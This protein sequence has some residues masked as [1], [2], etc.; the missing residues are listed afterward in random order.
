MPRE[1]RGLGKPNTLGLD[2]PSGNLRLSAM[3]P[4][5]LHKKPPYRRTPETPRPLTDALNASR[6]IG[7]SKILPMQPPI[8]PQSSNFPIAATN[9]S[10]LSLDIL[11]DMR[12]ISPVNQKETDIFS[13]DNLFTSADVRIAISKTEEEL[14][15][16]IDAFQAL[17][18]R[19]QRQILKQKAH[20]LPTTTP[21]TVDILLE[22][23]EWR[24]HRRIPS[25]PRS[26]PLLDS[27]HRHLFASTTR[28]SFASD[29]TSLR[30]ASSYKTDLSHPRSTASI[31]G[32]GSSSRSTPLNVGSPL[33]VSV[34]LHA[35]GK[36]NLAPPRKNS[37]SSTTTSMSSLKSR[38]GT[39]RNE[40]LLP[41]PKPSSSAAGDLRLSS[42]LSRSRSHLGLKNLKGSSWMF[43]EETLL[44]FSSSSR[45][46]TGYARTSG[47]SSRGQEISEMEID[48]DPALIDVR[49]R[50]E[51]LIARYNA[52]LEFLR[53]KLKSAELH[54]RLL[55]K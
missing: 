16:L 9:M 32:I 27:S 31:Y 51:R 12:P 43:S 22:G 39:T 34:L 42:M 49:R 29:G 24:E 48:N 1:G 38:S 52:R 54:E 55:R 28:D 2:S 45:E 53:A 7:T 40:S 20:R 5:L 21:A 4:K 14:S 30:S 17:E 36:R 8:S 47:S 15:K 18:T 11:Q 6:M 50:K 10:S 37:I 3:I 33:Q 23:K 19:T 46:E 26:A 13:D 25:I 41:A 44:S 35:N